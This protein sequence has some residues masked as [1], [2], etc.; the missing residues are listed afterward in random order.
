MIPL[1]TCKTARDLV[2]WQSL[3]QSH[4]VDYCTVVVAQDLCGACQYNI[5]LKINVNT[6]QILTSARCAVLDKLRSFTKCA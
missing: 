5:P 6:I 3:V 1:L 2:T 4:R